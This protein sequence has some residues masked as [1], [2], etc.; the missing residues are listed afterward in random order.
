[1]FRMQPSPGNI[2]TNSE[3]LSREGTP[4]NIIHCREILRNCLRPDTQAKHRG[5][6]TRSV[7]L[8]HH[9]AYVHIAIDTVDTVQ[10]VNFKVLEHFLYSPDLALLDDHVF[11]LLIGALRGHLFTS[12]K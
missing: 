7:A 5:I 1:M 6:V 2:R 11:D 4:V 8:L 10:K 12:D 9:N 3:T